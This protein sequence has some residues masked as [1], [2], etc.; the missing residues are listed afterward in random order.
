MGRLLPN[1]LKGNPSPTPPEGGEYK[2]L[3]SGRFGGG[4]YYFN[5]IMRKYI[6]FL[7]YLLPLALYS[8]PREPLTISGT[9]FDSDLKEPL[10]QATVQLF[11]VTDSTFVGGTV[12]NEEGTFSV[13]APTN[14]VF[15]LK[16]SSV[17]YQPIQ[18]E[19]TLRRN[20]GVDLGDL[21]ISPETVMLKETV[22]TAQVPQVGSVFRNRN[23]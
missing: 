20:Q 7:L 13:E 8:Q 10:M 5:N 22:V 11:T 18:R 16:I 3:P 17:G 15:R 9:V 1:G 19:V 21:L 12:T 4:H 6:L 2:S 23:N 14:G